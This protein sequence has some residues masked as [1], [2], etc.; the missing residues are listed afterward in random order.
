MQKSPD[1]TDKGAPPRKSSSLGIGE[2]SYFEDELAETAA[3]G[4]AVLRA[5]ASRWRDRVRSGR[6]GSRSPDDA[7]KLV[8]AL[9]AGAGIVERGNREDRAEATGR[10]EETAERFRLLIDGIPDYAIYM[11][12]REGKVSS[13]NSGAERIIGYRADEAIGRDA[14]QFYCPDDI[15]AGKPQRDLE[16]AAREGRVIEDG[17]RRRKNGERYSAQITLA[18]LRDPNGQLRG[19]ASIAR[20]TSEVREVVEAA[21]RTED[22]MRLMV[23]AVRDYAIFMLDPDGRIISWNT[24]AHR[25]Q[26]YNA[27]EIIGRHFS[28][29]YT[30]DAKRS[31][32][33]EEELRKAKADGRYEEEGIRVRKDGSRFWA[34]VVITAVHDDYGR[35]IGFSKVI[36]DFTERKAAEET[37]RQSEER[38]RVLVESVRDYAIFMLDPNGIIASWNAGAQR[39]KQYQAQE[40]IGRHFSVFY[41]EE[42]RARH[43]PEEELRIALDRGSYDEEGWRVRKDGTRFWASVVITALRDSHGK[44]VGFTKVTR[45]LTERKAAEEEL[46]ESEQRLRLLVES[47]KDYAIFMLD[48]DGRVASWNLG[49]ASIKGYRADEIIGKH[50]SVFYPPD[51]VTARRPEREL[52]IAAAEGRYEE[53]GY[54]VRKNGERFWAN[55]ILTAVHDP[56]TKELRGFAKVTRDLTERRKLEQ[57]ARAAAERAGME[58]ARAAEAQNALRMRDEFISVAAHELRT[59]L[60]ALQLKIQSVEMSLRGSS[61]PS[62]AKHL[63]RLL[64]ALRQT[65]RLSDL[66]ERLL[67]VSRIVQG[68]LALDYEEADLVSIARQVVDDLRE[69]ALH[70]ESSIELRAPATVTGCFDRA[71]MEQT[72]VNLLSNA[73]KYGGGKPIDVV[74]EADAEHARLSVRDRGIGIKPE[75]AERIFGRFERAVPTRHYGGLGLGLYVTR[76][77]VEAHGGSIGV[78][79]VPGEGA[80]FLVQVPLRRDEE[81]GMDKPTRA[82]G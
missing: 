61:T 7:L 59:P 54:R 66:V 2:P 81:D 34:N 69:Q 23:D 80:T 57:Q 71:R 51:D 21:R 32:H 4:S 43:H 41:E 11:L 48:P 55:V 49:A 40:I 28:I 18:A 65:S 76:S 6:L 10:F 38:F 31:G 47:V 30:E 72:L 56:V 52:Q 44:H 5:L 82:S 3:T 45:D 13:W 17:Y 79:S 63:E 70:A 68:R 67:D 22:R 42:D 50:F 78:Q 46:R 16:V 29:F 35:H 75:D 20:D 12:D 62:T 73:I 33:P 74:I 19:Y 37:L 1:P 8:A 64:G 14:A 24:G 60:T 15:A 77:I 58:Q 9:E 26:G 27:S 53:E 39:I 25:I 36:R